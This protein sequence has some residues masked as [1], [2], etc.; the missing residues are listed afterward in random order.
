MLTVEFK[1]NLIAPAQGDKLIATGRV[2]KSGR[3]LT[4]CEFEVLVF[5]DGNEQDLRARPADAD[6]RPGPHRHAA[7]GLIAPLRRRR[8]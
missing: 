3:T 6:V 4:I 8:S 7:V 1:I 2:K 5:R